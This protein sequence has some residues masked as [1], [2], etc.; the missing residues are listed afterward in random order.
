MLSLP[1]IRT[2][3]RTALLSALTVAVCCRTL[4]AAPDAR[5]NVLIM[6]SD[7]VSWPHA[8]AYGSK[9]VD[10]PVFDRVAAGGI[11]F[12]NAFCCAPG[13]SPSRAA[14]LTGRHIWM[15]EEAG[16]HAS[17]FKTQY[18]TFPERLAAAGYYTGS[19]GKG[20]GP[21]NFVRNG[22]QYNPAGRSFGRKGGY[23][24]G[25]QRFLKERPQDQPFCFWFGSSDAHR[26][27]VKGSGLKKGK[28]LSQAEVPGFLPDHEEIRSDLL[29]YAFE[30]ERFDDDCGKMLAALREAG[31]LDNTLVIITS[32]NGMPF[33]RAKANCY[34]FGI[35]MPLAIQ[36]PQ[37]FPGGRR[38]SDLVSFTDLTATIYEATGC[39]PPPNFPVVGRSLVSM[40]QS[41]QN[42][43]STE[44]RNFVL[45]GRERHSSS[46]YNSLGYPQRALRT[47]RYL[48]IHNFRPERAPA[49][50]A[51]KYDKA[52]FDNDGQLVMSELGKPFGGY[53]DIDACPTLTF[54]ID[55]Q[56]DP[57]IAR[58]LQLAVAHRP[59][60]ELFDI[61]ADPDCLH[62]LAADP[63]H[64][65]TRSSLHDT[66]MQQLKATG[67]ARVLDG[68]DIWETY[69]RVSGLRWFP[70]PDWAEQA[71]Q[72][73]KSLPQ[74]D[75][76]DERRPRAPQQQ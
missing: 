76:V 34:E 3:L 52:A 57:D 61:L 41:Q 29:D 71:T 45:S 22:R 43:R 70:K 69:P 37:Q 28:S 46:R 65:A 24:G 13:C 50:P 15:I 38:L 30:V 62:N 9:M 27:Y 4:C 12:D 72:K 8:S 7:D 59:A 54:L 11:L 44:E 63:K 23:I 31:E 35:H 56:D 21:G 47:E 16:T 20:W 42:G 40:L 18:Q 48:Y 14:L 36:W 6:I 58:Y 60:E 75:W 49:G 2:V 19:V 32:D 68:G 73:G 53:H 10:T 55:R 67:D 51:Q 39:Q 74:Q 17:Y 66:L 26:S 5:P 25:F 64:E 1:A 33:P